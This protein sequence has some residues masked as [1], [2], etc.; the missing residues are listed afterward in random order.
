M[1]FYPDLTHHSSGET[2][3]KVYPSVKIKN[4][5]GD[6]PSNTDERRSRIRSLMQT[7]WKSKK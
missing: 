4:K 5:D 7:F 3:S 6:D 1:A 2:W